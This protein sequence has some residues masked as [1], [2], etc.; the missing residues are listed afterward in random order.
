MVALET[1]G[2]APGSFDAVAPFDVL[3][4]MLDPGQTVQAAVNLLAPG[5]ILF[6]YV[7]NY[8]SASR[9]L[10][11]VNAHFIWP[12]HHLNYYTPAT[13]RDL[14]VRHGL[15]PELTVTEGPDLRTISGAGV[16]C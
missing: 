15:S 4:H 5:G 11:G 10:I 16:K 9:L 13:I 6:L 12:T 3:E 8:G 7:P 2:F 1:A 14:M